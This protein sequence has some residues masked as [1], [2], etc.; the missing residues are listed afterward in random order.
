MTQYILPFLAIATYITSLFF[1]A[2]LGGGTSLDGTTLLLFGWVQTLDGQC[3]AW[4]ANPIFFAALAFYILKQFKFAAG[5]SFIAILVALDT[6]R[7]T[8]FP[9]NEAYEVAIDSVG[10]A[11]YVW[12]TSF[13][14]LLLVSLYLVW[15]N[16]HEANT[17]NATTN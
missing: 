2:L 15:V 13:I 6:F 16:W 12:M 3:I 10:L 1:P 8:K 14:L 9:P 7:A 11:F 17:H 4:L 5:L